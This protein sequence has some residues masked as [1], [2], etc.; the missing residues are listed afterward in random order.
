ME[1]GAKDG[2]SQSSSSSLSPDSEPVP[3]ESDKSNS[4]DG[5]HDEADTSEEL[6][7]EIEADLLQD[8]DTSVYSERYTNS[9]YFRK[10]AGNLKSQKFK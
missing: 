3:A 7:R 10:K 2:S 6:T 5:D 1:S 8:Y 4:T 9:Y